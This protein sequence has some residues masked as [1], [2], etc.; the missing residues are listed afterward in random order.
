MVCP[1]DRY[2]QKSA[3]NRRNYQARKL[4]AQYPGLVPEPAPKPGLPPVII[5]D[6]EAELAETKALAEVL[7][8]L[9]SRW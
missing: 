4:R 2:P 8:E 7:A 5:R 1:S 6:P 3:R 9:S